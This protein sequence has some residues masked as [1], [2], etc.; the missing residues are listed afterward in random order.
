MYLWLGWCFHAHLAT[1][2]VPPVQRLFKIRILTCLSFKH[3]G[4]TSTAFSSGVSLCEVVVVVRLNRVL[5][6]NLFYLEHNC[7]LICFNPEH[8]GVTI[9]WL[10][11][12]RR[13]LLIWPPTYWP[14]SQWSGLKKQ[15]PWWS[16]L[17]SESH[18]EFCPWTKTKPLE[19]LWCCRKNQVL[20]FSVHRMFPLK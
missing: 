8:W 15:L 9:I 13:C 6:L 1:W 11:G 19:Q 2:W 20:T 10:T 3:H 7:S 12:E 16:H 18:S 4:R 17:G 5:L 14:S